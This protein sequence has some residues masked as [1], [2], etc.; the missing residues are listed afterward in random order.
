MVASM[1]DRCRSL[2]VHEEV[3]KV[4]LHSVDHYYWV[5][6]AALALT[7]DFHPFAWL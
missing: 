7:T 4:E 3:P 5:A 1:W 2:H 6:W